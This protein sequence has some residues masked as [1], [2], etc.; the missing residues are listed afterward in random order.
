VVEEADFDVV[1][2]SGMQFVYGDA[3][4]RY[5]VRGPVGKLATE[6]VFTARDGAERSSDSQSAQVL[7]QLYSQLLGSPIAQQIGMEKHIEILAEI[8]RLSGSSIDMSM[9]ALTSPQGAAS[10][11]A[12]PSPLNVVAPPVATG[13]GLAAAPNI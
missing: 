10:A 5:T 13:A 4:D 1:N 9:D 8:F 7:A 2:S 6:L 3:A 11:A 12:G